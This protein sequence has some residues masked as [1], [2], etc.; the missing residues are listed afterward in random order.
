MAWW[1]VIDP[2]RVDVIRSWNAP[3]SVANVGWYPTALVS[4]PRRA[5]TSLP[6]CNYPTP[7]TKVHQANE[8]SEIPRYRRRVS[9]RNPWAITFCR[10]LR[11]TEA[12][13]LGH[14]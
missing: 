6:A 1:D 11:S 13:G 9:N 12:N 8:G 2:F 5:D 4:L 10:E 7:A 14:Q 3:I